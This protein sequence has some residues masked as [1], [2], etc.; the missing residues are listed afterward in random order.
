MAPSVT[1]SKQAST[2]LGVAVARLPDAVHQTACRWKP[3]AISTFCSCMPGSVPTTCRVLNRQ[4]A[5]LL[6]CTLCSRDLLS[7]AVCPS[8]I[9]FRL[10]SI[11]FCLPQVHQSKPRPPARGPPRRLPPLM[12]M[13]KAVCQTLRVSRSQWPAPTL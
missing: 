11:A 8:S 2:Q 4:P 13:P 1:A 5:A 9:A 10:P 12:L 7:I 3:A 6:H